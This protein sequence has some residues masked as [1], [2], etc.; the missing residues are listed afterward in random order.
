MGYNSG[1]E[2]EG[3]AVETKLFVNDLKPFYHSLSQPG[4]VCGVTSIHEKGGN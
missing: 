4:R 1:I 3:F 2:L